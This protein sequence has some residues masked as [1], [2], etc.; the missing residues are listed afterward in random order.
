M[1]ILCKTPWAF[2]GL[3]LDGGL[4]NLLFA[5]LSAVRGPSIPIT[6]SQE[7]PQEILRSFF[8][9]R[10]QTLTLVSQGFGLR[11]APV[12]AKP[13]STGRRAPHHLLYNFPQEYTL[14][15]FT[16]RCLLLLLLRFIRLFR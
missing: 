7:R 16:F 6:C 12:G 3:F 8:A 13:T 9:S 4:S 11:S 2:F 15:L 1:P 10:A 5:V 14:L